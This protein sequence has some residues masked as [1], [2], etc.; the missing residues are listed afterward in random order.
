[1]WQPVF[2]A[3]LVVPVLFLPLTPRLLSYRPPGLRLPLLISAGILLLGIGGGTAMLSLL[4]SPDL[5]AR[6]VNVL[7]WW[8]LFGWLTA[9]WASL[10]TDPA[11]LPHFS[12]AVRTLVAALL[13]VVFSAPTL[14][15]WQEALW[16]APRWAAQC[17]VRDRLYRS[18]HNWHR[19]LTVPPITQVIPRYVLVRGYDI[20]PYYEHP[21]NLSVAQYFHLDSVRTDVRWPTPASF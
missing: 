5:L 17:E 1:M 11:Q 10:P 4:I 20:Q 12:A 18:P 7:Y 15:A 2:F 6:G 21:L 19:K 14:R 16:E 9:C 13:V 8:T 3:L